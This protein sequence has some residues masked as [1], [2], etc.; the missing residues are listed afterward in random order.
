VVAYLTDSTTGA[1]TTIPGQSVPGAPLAIAADPSGQ[2]AYVS[3]DTAVVGITAFRI[4]P[5][6][7]GLGFILAC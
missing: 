6:T 2:F 5:L 4:D 3:Y 7:G 1:L